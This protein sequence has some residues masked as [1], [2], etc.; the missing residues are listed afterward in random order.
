MFAKLVCFLLFFMPVLAKQQPNKDSGGLV[1]ESSDEVAAALKAAL[2][3]SQGQSQSQEQ[4]QGQEGQGQTQSQTQSQ[5]QTEAQEQSQSQSQNQKQ[6]VETKKEGTE[7]AN[8]D[9]EEGAEGNKGE[10]SGTNGKQMEQM[11]KMEQSGNGTKI[12]MEQNLTIT[13]DSGLET[14][15]DPLDQLRISV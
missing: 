9:L 14:D 6:G 1:K 15:Q 7:S 3:A 5:S 2:K 11:E 4:A 10:T 8:N 12:S 13:P